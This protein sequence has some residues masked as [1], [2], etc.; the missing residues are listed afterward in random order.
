MLSIT[1]GIDDL[2]RRGLRAG[3][4]EVIR[5]RIRPIVIGAM[6]VLRLP[7]IACSVS[8]ER[9]EQEY[10]AGTWKYVEELRELARYSVI[11][12]YGAYFKPGGSVLDVGCG[13]G[14]LQRRVR[15]L[16]YSHYL[17]I[18]GSETAIAQALQERDARTEFLCADAEIYAP[19]ESFDVI[20]FNEILYYLS[21]PVGIFQRMAR[22]LNPEG[23]VVVSMRQTPNS[24]PI[25]RSLDRVA[26]TL[27]A[28]MVANQ[29]RPWEIKVFQPK[30]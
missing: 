29:N 16:G 26:R 2:L 22:A 15:A 6:K 5:E 13:T 8:K 11:I 18:D 20:I 3:L 10:A 30:V 7:Y 25:W 19:Q 9:W 1:M 23:I 14:L 17:G 21:D 24:P 28:V 27:D 4:P 12:G